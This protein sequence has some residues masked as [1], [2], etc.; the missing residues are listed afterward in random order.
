MTWAECCND[1]NLVVILD[2]DYSVSADGK[3]ITATV[4]NPGLSGSVTAKL[5]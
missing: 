5:R 1:P 3:T 2:L 4:T